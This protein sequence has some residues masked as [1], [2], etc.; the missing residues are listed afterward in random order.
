VIDPV[1]PSDLRE[2]L[3]NHNFRVGEMNDPS[4]VLSSIY[5]CLGKIPV[6]KSKRYK[7]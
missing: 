5:D 7:G 2:A 1:D 6:L 4:E 3:D